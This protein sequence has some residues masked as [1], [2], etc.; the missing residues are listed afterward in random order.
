MSSKVA[1]SLP[2][3]QVKYKENRYAEHHQ[4]NLPPSQLRVDSSDF[5]P[6]GLFLRENFHNLHESTEKSVVRNK[7]KANHEVFT[8]EDD[9]KTEECGGEDALLNIFKQQHPHPLKAQ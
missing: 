6:K 5:V 1:V 8:A 9:P 3:T 7:S 4:T 2:F